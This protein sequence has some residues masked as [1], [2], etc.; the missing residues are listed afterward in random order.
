MKRPDESAATDSNATGYSDNGLQPATIYYYRI[1]AENWEASSSFTE[2]VSTAT[3]VGVA[4][5]EPGRPRTYVLY[6]NFPNPF[7]PATKLVYSL[8]QPSHVRLEIYNNFGRRIATLVN[9]L[10]QP[11]AYEYIWDAASATG[12]RCGSG[13]YLARLQ[14]GDFSKTIKL[15]LMK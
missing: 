6:Q 1:R 5:T 12:N 11:G 15:L 13:V 14:A 8:P 7:N 2:S 3:L 9:G 10:Q 4:D